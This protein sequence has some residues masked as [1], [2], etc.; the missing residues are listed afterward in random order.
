MKLI[1]YKKHVNF[2]DA[3]NPMVF[4][5]FL[6]GFFD[7][8]EDSVF[9]G[10]GSILHMKFPDASQKIVFSSG[11]AYYGE[12]PRIDSSYYFSCVRGPL[13]CSALKIDKK[14]SITDGAALLKRF[15][16]PEGK[17]KTWFFFYAS[18]RKR[19]KL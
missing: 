17:K 18:P 8:N 7:K 14:Y 4:N 5:R 16:L 2:G 10:I 15:D 1:Y 19:F 11:F 3:L 6:P 12:M 9:I 13:T